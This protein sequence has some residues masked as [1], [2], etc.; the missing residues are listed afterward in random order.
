MNFLFT[1]LILCIFK[2]WC[3]IGLG[4]RWQK[5]KLKENFELFLK[6]FKEIL[7]HEELFCW[8]SA[9]PSFTNSAHIYLLDLNPLFATIRPSTHIKKI[10]T[11][12]S[13]IQLEKYFECH[14]KNIFFLACGRLNDGKQWLKRKF[15]CKKSAVTIKQ[16]F[17]P[18]YACGRLSM[19][20]ILCGKF[21]NTFMCN[22]MLVNWSSLLQILCMD[23]CSHEIFLLIC[24]VFFFLHWHFPIILVNTNFEW[25]FP[26]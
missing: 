15:Y 6:I 11:T 2:G 5:Y 14:R 19:D 1:G 21:S 12:F 20:V 23:M 8:Y 26:Y 18:T 3:L 7:K 25:S 24:V 13:S 16:N 4:S 10:K 9:N 17:D 22:I